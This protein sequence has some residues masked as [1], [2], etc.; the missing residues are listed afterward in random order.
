MY[1]ENN[2]NKESLAP[3][4]NQT[5]SSII[6]PGPAKEKIRDNAVNRTTVFRPIFAIP[7]VAIIK[8]IVRSRQCCN[9]PWRHYANTHRNFRLL[10]NSLSHNVMTHIGLGMS[11]T[12]RDT[13]R[14]RQSYRIETRESGRNSYVCF[15]TAYISSHTHVLLLLLLL[16]LFHSC[17]CGILPVAVYHIKTDIR[18]AVNH[19]TFY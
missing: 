13:S 10:C 18:A 6:Q 4:G 15:P 14:Q 2:I 5:D 11:Q 8:T 19:N 17:F 1:G 12:P 9:R 16:L 3:A 7:N